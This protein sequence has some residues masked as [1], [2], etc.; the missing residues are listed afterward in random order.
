MLEN[1]DT[2]PCSGAG[3]GGQLARANFVMQHRIKE[4]HHGV[5]LSCM[6]GL[7]EVQ[8]SV[9]N[10]DGKVVLKKKRNFFYMSKRQSDFQKNKPSGL[11]HRHTSI[12]G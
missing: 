10:T 6:S 3:Y 1:E 2:V 12:G 9:S 11:L 7:S 4:L 8:I 5:R